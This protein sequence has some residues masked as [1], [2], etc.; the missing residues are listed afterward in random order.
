[1]GEEAAV[2]ASLDYALGDLLRAAV[3]NLTEPDAVSCARIDAVL[4]RQMASHR[5]LAWALAEAEELKHRLKAG[6]LK[7][8]YPSDEGGNKLS[9]T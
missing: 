7:G 9:E 3:E 6:L 1:M 4:D 5:D 8:P 2:R